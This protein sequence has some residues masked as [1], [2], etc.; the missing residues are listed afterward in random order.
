ML[1]ELLA[2]PDGQAAGVAFEGENITEDGASCF[3]VVGDAG[4]G[5]GKEDAVEGIER[6]KNGGGGKGVPWGE[7]V[8]HDSK[9]EVK[10]DDSVAAGD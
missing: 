7:V 1:G 9:N 3:R 4:E 5:F 10:V 2:A 6:G 8:S